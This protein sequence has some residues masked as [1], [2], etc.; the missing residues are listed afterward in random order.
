M[1]Q[2]PI[3]LSECCGHVTE[4]TPCSSLVLT[5]IPFENDSPYMK[6][7]S[8]LINNRSMVADAFPIPAEGYAFHMFCGDFHGTAP[9]EVLITGQ[10][11]GSGDYA[12]GQLYTITP[13]KLIPIITD[14]EM[15]K[16]LTYG[17]QFTPNKRVKI[18]CAETMQTFD[19]HIS[20]FTQEQLDVIYN[21]DGSVREGLTP[22]VSAINTIYPIRLPYTSYYTLQIQQRIIGINNSDTLGLIQSIIDVKEDNSLKVIDQYL[23]LPG[24]TTI[25]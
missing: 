13:N 6:N 12:I 24:Y 11:G 18:T 1:K 25:P 9:D 8:V 17:V 20:D 5:G 19:I 2:L 14:V 21:A 10:Y 4:D 23:V 16:L 15:N 22:S 3:V 7:L